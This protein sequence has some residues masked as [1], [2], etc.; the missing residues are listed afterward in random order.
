MTLPIVMRR[1]AQTEF[2]DAVEWYET[3]RP[4]VADRFADAVKS[5]LARISASP[6]RHAVVY[7]DVRKALVPKFPYCVY[8]VPDSKRILVISVFHTSRD[9]AIWKGRR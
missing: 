7:R 1:A 2:D 4:G 8:Y 9:P 6:K 5:T 3:Q